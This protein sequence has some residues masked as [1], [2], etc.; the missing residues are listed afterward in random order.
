MMAL[1]RRGL[2]AAALA[3][4]LT[5]GLYGWFRYFGQRMG[6]FGPEPSPWQGIWHHLHVLAAPL[7]LFMLGVVLRGHLLPKL[8][9]GAREGR[10][11]GLTLGLL[12]APMVLSGYGIQV[13][14]EARWHV[15][16]AWI[17][18]LSSLLFVS[19]YLVHLIA[20]W[21]YRRLAEDEA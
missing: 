6:D 18:G 17:H 1:E 19:A 20:I 9:A 7:L 2:H 15:A 10:R 12:V 21:R 16:L 5:G 11:T 4:A 14:T 8:R 13:V 3:A